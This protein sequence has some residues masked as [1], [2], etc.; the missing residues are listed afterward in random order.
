MGGDPTWG[1]G[2]VELTSS[3]FVIF[4]TIIVVAANI[5]ASIRYR[6]ALL[7]GANCFVIAS[8]ITSPI[9]LLG[10]GALL[11]LGYACVCAVRR[12][13]SRLVVAAGIVATVGLF[14]YLKRYAFVAAI[15]ALPFTYLTLGLSYILFRIIHLIVDTAGGD[16]KKRVGLVDYYNYTCN[17]LTFISG[18]IQRFQDYLADKNAARVAGEA[19]A[20]YGFYR[21]VIGYLKILVVSAFANAVFQKLNVGLFSGGDGSTLVYCIRYMICAGLY[22]IFLYYNFSGFIDVVIGFGRLMGLNLPENFNQPFKV[23]NFLDFWGRWH[24]TLSHWF[25]DYMFNPLLRALMGR[26]GDASIAP[27]L[28]VFGFFLTFT[29]MGIWHGATTVFLVY[30]LVMGA[31]ASLNK[32]YQLWIVARLGRKRYRALCQS[33]VYIYF[34][35][36]MTFAYFTMAVTALWVDLAQLLGIGHALG[37]AGVLGAF[38]GLTVIGAFALLAGDMVWT[39]AVRGSAALRPKGWNLMERTV[40][41]ACM[42]LL[43]LAVNSL[44]RGPP[45]FVYRA[46]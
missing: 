6:T 31:G 26:F 39:A 32:A 9:Q 12:W 17:F 41:L 27:A 8:Y 43:T 40:G 37:V 13:Q 18:P 35:R 34:C 38:V 10:L 45:A 23:A 20:Y 14:L 2:A 30:G 15:P 22:T 29:V 19:D 11:I 33:Q 1:W 46:F 36:G 25:R 42:I 44:F 28:G 3:Q 16:L 7:L 5:S 24:M 21:V 4:S